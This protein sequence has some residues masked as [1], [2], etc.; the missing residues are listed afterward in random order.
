MTSQEINMLDHWIAGSCIHKLDRPNRFA[1]PCKAHIGR[2]KR[3]LAVIDDNG[4]L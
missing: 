4:S 1:Q 2:T 3:T